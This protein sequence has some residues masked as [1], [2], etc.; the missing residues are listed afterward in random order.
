MQENKLVR[1]LKEGGSWDDF[2][3]DW[4]SQC[5]KLNE[6][7]ESYAG[8][9]FEVVKEIVEQEKKRAGMFAVRDND[10]FHAM[11]QANTASLPGYNGPVL[12]VRFITLSPEHD[13]TD[14]PL[15]E[16]A[17]VLI[18]VLAHALTIASNDAELGARHIK[19]HLRSPTD[20][21]F[22]AALGSGLRDRN[23]FESIHT[24]GLWL[25]ITM[26]EKEAAVAA[27]G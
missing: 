16:Y 13:L 2:E 17:E 24:R 14:K 6:D 27:K 20:Q 8:A 26:K 25:Y 21:Q 3:A 19:M 10:R 12:R 18:S 22:F 15:T 23:V 4:R 11:F 9:T 7:F 5:E 1:L